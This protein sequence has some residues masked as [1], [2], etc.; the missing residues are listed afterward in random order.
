MLS[1]KRKIYEQMMKGLFHNIFDNTETESVNFLIL[2]ELNLNNTYLAR[3]RFGVA[4]LLNTIRVY[5]KPIFSHEW[6]T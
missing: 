1:P 2:I 6:Y 4:V 5:H 3:I